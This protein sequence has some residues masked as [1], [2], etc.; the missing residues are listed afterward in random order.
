MPGPNQA[1]LRRS[2]GIRPNLAKAHLGA[3]DLVGRLVRVAAPRP[4]SRTAGP[5]VSRAAV[6]GV[7]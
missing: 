1:L 2:L 7:T 5:P 3:T 4:H 6:G